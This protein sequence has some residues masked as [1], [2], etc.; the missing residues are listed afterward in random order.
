MKIFKLK[1]LYAIFFLIL[2]PIIGLEV[3]L[4]IFSPI[5]FSGY[6]GNYRYH[7]ILGS[8]LKE[9]YFTKNTDYKQEV[10]VNKLGTVNPQN[11]FDDYEKIAF[12]LGD[13]FTQGT[14]SSLSASYPSF[15]DLI[16]NTNSGLYSPNVGVVNLG[17]SANGGLQNIENYKI[18]KTKI[19][20]PNYVFYLGCD[21]DLTDDLR[22]KGGYRHK[23]IVDG[24]PYF[25]FMVKPLQ[26]LNN[27]ETFKRLKLLRQDFI[28]K[29]IASSTKSNKA[30]ISS[31]SCNSIASKSEA[32]LKKLFDLSKND[33]FTLIVSWVY[34]PKQDEE[35]SSYNWIKNWAIKNKIKFA[36]Y[37]ESVISA[38]DYWV[39]MPLENDHSGGHYRSWINFLIADSF[40]KHIKQ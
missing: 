24:S 10:F 12:A 25:G 26:I 18:Y 1:I 22:F 38:K 11:N 32:V 4:K 14:G 5:R 3:F 35:C 6:I 15:A 31:K 23:Q 37:K 36:D 19:R 28:T 7:P 2:L 30:S 8:V 40:S 20:K 33:N 21:N 16:I 17:T 13:S 34:Y 9:G 39:N 27:L 29:K